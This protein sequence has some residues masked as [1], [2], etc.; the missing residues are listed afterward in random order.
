MFQ[1]KGVLLWLIVGNDITSAAFYWSKQITR[2]AQFQEV[3]KEISSFDGND[4]KITLQRRMK[5]NNSGHFCKKISTWKCPLYYSVPLLPANA[6]DIRGTGSIPGSGRWAGEG[7]GT[8]LQYCLENP[9]DRGAW[10]VAVH[11]VTNSQTWLKQPSMHAQK[12]VFVCHVQLFANLWTIAH[13]ATLSMKFS[14]QAYWNG[15]PFPLLLHHALLFSTLCLRAYSVKSDSAAPWS[16]VCQTP[17]S[18][19]FS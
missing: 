2:S 18:I 9:K 4:S 6:G 15:L 16:I 12:C 10:W 7:N 3:E 19:E 5:S 13:Q 17:L 8:P 1:E 14:R 11:R